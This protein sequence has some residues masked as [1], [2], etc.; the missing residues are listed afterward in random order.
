LKECDIPNPLS[1]KAVIATL[2]SVTLPVPNLLI[3][4]ALKKLD[5]TVP[6]ATIIEIIPAYEM[7][8]DKSL[9]IAGQAEP[10]SESGK[11]RLMK[12]RYIIISK[13]NN[14]IPLVVLSI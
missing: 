2:I 7:A 14:C 11:P 13:V 8:T 3:N 5:I 1:A 9:Y 4:L 12:E 10:S 6:P